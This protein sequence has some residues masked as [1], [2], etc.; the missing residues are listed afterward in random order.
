[1][2]EAR[3]KVLAAGPLV[4]VQDAERK[5]FMRFGVAASGPLDRLSHAAGN[6]ALGNSP[7][8]S[9]IEVSMGGLVLECISGALSLAVT[10]ADCLVETSGESMGSWNVI[11]L[12]PGERLSIRA[13]QKG[14][15]SYLAFAGDLESKTWLGHSATHSTSGFGG[16]ALSAGQVLTVRECAV[17]EDRHGSI[18]RPAVAANEAIRVVMGPQDRFFDPSALSALQEQPFRLSAQFDRMGVRLEGPKLSIEGALSIPSEPVAKGAIQ[19]AGDGRPTVLLADHQTTGGYPKIATV[20][21]SDLDRISQMRAGDVVRFEAVSPEQAVSIA[22]DKA[23]KMQ[24]YLE[25]V[26]V[27]RGTL[28]QRLMR[29]NLISGAVSE[30]PD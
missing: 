30:T 22:R 7:E 1:M 23:L 20:I 28:A 13:G 16:G 6:A 24:V 21:S 18:Q 9:G 19:V 25:E 10:G 8:A 27:P 29:E 11:S 26:A 14:S 5:G 2:G 15:W 17:R 12:S 3:L 4:T